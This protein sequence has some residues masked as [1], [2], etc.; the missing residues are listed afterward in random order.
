MVIAV[1]EAKIVR[2]ASEGVQTVVIA[3]QECKGIGS[4][5]I[6]V[7][8][9]IIAA[10]GVQRPLGRQGSGCPVVV[11]A[12]LGAKSHLSFQLLSVYIRARLRHGIFLTSFFQEV[13]RARN[14]QNPQAN[15]AFCQSN[16]KPPSD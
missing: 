4:G 13:H 12:A 10:S 5:I 14:Y 11:L 15:P 1:I 8:P 9:V 3:N 7:S 2:D 6:R 16:A